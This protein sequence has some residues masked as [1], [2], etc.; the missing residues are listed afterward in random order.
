[1][2]KK[3]NNAITQGVIW[4]EMLKYFFP[5]LFGT[6][7]QQLYNTVDAIIVGRYVGAQALAAVGGSASVIVNLFVGFFTGLASGA[8]VIIAQFYGAKHMNDVKKAIHTGI[9]ISIIG[10]IIFTIIGLC[11]APFGI[12]ILNTPKDTIN[13]SVLYLRIYFIGM[14][15]NLVYNMGAGILRA[16]GDSVRPLITLIIATICNIILDILFVYELGMGVKGVAIATILCQ[17]ISAII[18]ISMLKKLDAEYKL[19][20][21]DIRVDGPIVL[22]IL[23]IGIPAGVQSSMYSLS[24]LVIQTAIN[25]FGT[26]AVSAW[27]AYGKVDIL[28][29]LIV[30]SLGTSITTF[31]GQNYGAGK[32]KRVRDSVRQGLVITFI[33]TVMLS[34]I[35]YFYRIP[36]LK[37]FISEADVINYG[38]IM[39]KAMV[40]FYVL[41][42]SVEVFSGALRGMGEAI[43]PTLLSLFGI[44]IMRVLWVIFILPLNNEVT[45]IVY[46]YPVTWA[47]TSF[48][49]I[50]YYFYVIKKKHRF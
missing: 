2:Q 3:N 11:L 31:V 42:I 33:F 18:V 40:P 29:W 10:G 4:K 5:L 39:M 49:F 17:L 22:K 9:A 30:G 36:L 26:Y 37:I 35:F 28:L 6:F 13:D 38:D 23:H 8:T 25:S 45:T 34:L 16:I 27:A 32:P 19:C 14:I 12:E 44:C 24:N 47:L 21:K 43:I 1:M 15:P 50:L 48:M 41:Y 20:I 46:S 7:F